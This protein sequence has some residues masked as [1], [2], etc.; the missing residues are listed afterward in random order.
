MKNERWIICFDLETDGPD[1]KIC[2]P[3][4]I[5]AVPINPDTLEIKRDAIFHSMIRPPN[6]DKK[7]YF[8]DDIKK[9]I[10]WHAKKR[11][12]TEEEIV[13]LWKSARD[14]KVVWKDFCLFC[15]KFTV[16]KKPGQWYPEPIPAGYN[17]AKY[18]MPILTRLA[19]KYKT[20]IPMSTVSE[21]DFMDAVLWW[22][23]SL[24]E[25]KDYK[26]DTLRDFFGMKATG[27]AHTAISDVQ[28][29][30][31]WIVRFLKFHRKQAS[32]SKFKNSFGK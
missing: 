28:D 9:T 21:F 23:E 1:P 15:S 17:I 12:Q 11:D 18:D 24:D 5:A 2:N 27:A 30:A 31:E 19:E 14:E 29:T 10:A 13:Q 7:E 8:T 6:I 26:A 20:K 32:V 22:F 4:E 3:V 25:P 16:D